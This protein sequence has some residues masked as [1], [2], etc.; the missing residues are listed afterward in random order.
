[1]A[2]HPPPADEALYRWRF[3]AV[4]FDEARHELRIAGLGVDIE[5]KPLEVLSLLLRHAGEVVTKQELF[6]QVWAG[7]VTVDHVLATAV[8]K[9]RKELD[10][11]GEN[12]IATVP[13]MGYRFDG[14]VERL[15]VGRAQASP[16]ALAIG[17]PVPGRPHFLLE[18][19]LG[20]TL[21]SEVWLARQPRSRDAR[22]FKFALDGEHLATIKREATLLRVLHDT[23][24]ARDDMARALDWNF[25]SPP[26]FLECAYG[27]QS[28]PEWAAEGHLQALS[29]EARIEVFAAVVEAVAAAHGAGVL[30]KDLKPANVLISPRGDGWQPRLTDFGSSR[31]LQPER[32]SA[33]GITGL[34]LTVTSLGTDSTSGTPLYLAPELLAGQAPTVRSD[35]Y[36]LGVML[37]QWLV[38]DLR[39]PLASGWEREIDDP[40]LR[41]DI[42][43][44]TDVDPERR[45]P[46][47]AELAQRLR[48]LPRRRDEQSRHD[49]AELAAAALRRD[50]ERTRT[51]RPW[52]LATIAVLGVGLLA[53]AGL[54]RHSERQHRNAVL[55]ASRAEAVVRFL[56][57]DLLGALS[58]GGSGF[59]R[60]PT[61]REA[62]EYASSHVGDRFADD[63]ATLGSVHAALGQAWRTL[64]DR[65]RSVRHLRVAVEQFDR[66]F[67]AANALTLDTR[68]ALA[69]SLAYV[70]DAGAFAEAAR[71]LAETDTLAGAQLHADGPLALSAAF[72]RG[73]LYSQQ[74][75]VASAVDAWHRADRL[76]RRLLP[77]DAQ[78]AAII[79]ENLADG[80]LRSGQAE[81][82]ITLL[83]A[84]LADPLL[85][86]ERV[87]E[88]QVAAYQGLLARALRNQGR[89]REALPLAQAAAATMDKV[90]GSGNY[91]AI[92]QLSLVASIHQGAG[93]CTAA[94]AAQR[95]VRERMAGS[96]GEDRQA[97]LVETGNLGMMEHE[98]GDPDAGIAYLERAERGLRERHGADNVA[99]H[100]FRYFLAEAL[101]AQRRYD[102]AAAM[103]DGLDAA[104]L[105]AGDS[106]PGW[107]GRLAA[108][109]DQIRR[110]ASP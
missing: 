89:H 73:I 47:A 2:S 10:A 84:M 101:V 60:D 100:S 98:C 4:E 59:E 71:L 21:G 56:G 3:G 11:A 109:R 66:A 42:A 62:L 55:Q 45:V 19:Q 36:A 106:A 41:A 43:Q 29:R 37:Y 74:M 107:D 67:G 96:Y 40:L 86:P 23:L 54:W 99:A 16:L 18:R 34:G 13:R 1:M 90:F 35:I 64:G 105:T 49:A 6:D 32:L 104:T 88:S 97:T 39:R 22:V 61:V 38:G 52:V 69:R 24:G 93:D 80:L 108:L 65:E 7:R 17:Q 33:L 48:E 110:G 70:N 25:E 30:H 28:L 95:T 81:Q 75:Q 20:R 77:D 14:P 5:H 94:L 57:E 91:Q 26:F 15:A 8:S 78:M 12:R 27:G 82:G 72:A 87:G 102:E 79:R 9:L 44:A 103:A 63:P 31:L 68:Y 50:L 83:Q 76:Q 58:P 53:T 51:R 92:V 46:S 85:D